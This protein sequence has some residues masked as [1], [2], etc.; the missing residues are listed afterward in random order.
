M[1]IGLRPDPKPGKLKPERL[2]KELVKLILGS[3]ANG[4]SICDALAA[5]LVDDVAVDDVETLLVLFR[6]LEEGELVLAAAAAAADM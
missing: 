2:S 5:E 1:D 6:E 3:P 4:K